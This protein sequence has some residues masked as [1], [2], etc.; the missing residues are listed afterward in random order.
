VSEA[1]SEQKAY[2]TIFLE[3]KIVLEQKKGRHV[4]GLPF[5]D[6]C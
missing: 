5:S 2:Y 4:K 6:L 1:K 3:K